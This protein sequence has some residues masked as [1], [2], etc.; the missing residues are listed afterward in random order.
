MASKNYAR[1]FDLLPDSVKKVAKKLGRRFG[2]TP[3][4]L[5]S[6]LSPI[7]EDI[8]DLNEEIEDLKLDIDRQDE[9]ISELE[10]KKDERN[11][12]LRSFIDSIYSGNEDILDLEDT[13]DLKPAALSESVSLEPNTKLCVF[14]M[15]SVPI[16]LEGQI[17]NFL[18]NMKNTF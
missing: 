6:Y 5:A 15:G 13:S 16:N 10:I 17:D 12:N 11:K 4:Q 7:V 8:A 14:V 3:E 9:Y 2:T 18:T 1:T